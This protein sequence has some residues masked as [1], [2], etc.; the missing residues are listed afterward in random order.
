M[1]ADVVAMFDVSA[2]ALLL[3]TDRPFLAANLPRATGF[4]NTLPAEY[5]SPLTTHQRPIPDPL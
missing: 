3:R 2:S 1:D 4:V 5:Y